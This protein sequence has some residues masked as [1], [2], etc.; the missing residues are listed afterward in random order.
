MGGYG[1]WCGCHP[2]PFTS[3]LLWG[4]VVALARPWPLW[5]VTKQAGHG[6]PMVSGVALARSGLVWRGEPSMCHRQVADG[7]VWAGISWSLTAAAFSLAVCCMHVFVY[8]L[9]AGLGLLWRCRMPLE[10]RSAMR[11]HV[12]VYLLVGCSYRV[13]GLVAARVQKDGYLWG[14]NALRSH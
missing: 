1:W 4:S 7:R 9:T 3:L 8:L 5:P 12:I 11:W 14:L 13:R 2:H 10:L 6:L